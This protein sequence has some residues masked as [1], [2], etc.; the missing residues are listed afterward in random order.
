MDNYALD[1]TANIQMRTIPTSASIYLY[2]VKDKSFRKTTLREIPI[3]ATM[4]D[5]KYEIIDENL[6]VFAK[7][8]RANATEFI[9]IKY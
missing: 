5:D 2:D 8:A 4:Q 1:T 6:M 9:F 3:N 7:T